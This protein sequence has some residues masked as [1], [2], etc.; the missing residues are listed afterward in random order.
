MHTKRIFGG[1]RA[2]FGPKWVWSAYWHN[3][4]TYEFKTLFSITFHIER[5]HYKHSKRHFKILNCFGWFLTC[6][7]CTK[8]VFLWLRFPSVWPE[9]LHLAHLSYSFSNPT[10]HQNGGRKASAYLSSEPAGPRTFSE[11][12]TCRP[13]T[14]TGHA[15]GMGQNWDAA[16][17]HSQWLDNQP[18][19]QKCC[20][21]WVSTALSEPKHEK[22]SIHHL[23]SPRVL[24]VPLYL[25]EK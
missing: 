17:N 10:K 25:R 8:H 24:Y 21:S 4:Y 12:K 6:I 11:P 16:I 14:H 1:K 13:E 5:Y 20:Q 7:Y 23:T 15:G 22:Y 19:S 3:A 9:D 18:H 2:K